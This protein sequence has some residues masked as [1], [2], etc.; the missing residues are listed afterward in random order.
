MNIMTVI[1]ADMLDSV[2]GGATP[3]SY[4]ITV[5]PNGLSTESFTYDGHT[6]NYTYQLSP[7]QY[8]PGSYS[9]SYPG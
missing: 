7:N 9:Y 2:S 3:Y 5:A 8:V 6:S 1:P 4:N